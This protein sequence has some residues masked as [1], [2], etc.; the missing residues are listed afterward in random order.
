MKKKKISD[1][2]VGYACNNNCVHC[3]ISDNRDALLAQ[4]ASINRT[5]AECKQE[6]LNAK[7]MGTDE[8]VL[9]GG[10]ATIRKDF[11]DLLSIIYEQGLRVNLQ[12]NGRAF[13]DY[14]FAKKTAAFPNIYFTLALHGHNAEFHDRITQK[15]GSF[16]ETTTGI[17][18]LLESNKFVSIKLVLSKFNYKYLNELIELLDDLKIRHFNL[19]FPHGLGNASRYFFDVVPKYSEVKD[20]IISALEHSIKKNILF[21]TE[22]IPYCFLEGYEEFASEHFSVENQIEVRAIE[23]YTDNWHTKRLSIKKKGEKCIQCLFSEICEGPWV[24]YIENYGDSELKPI[25]ITAKNMMYILKKFQT[26]KDFRSGKKI[27][28]INRDVCQEINEKSM[29]LQTRNNKENG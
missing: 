1:I 15:N 9:T 13:Y 6:I 21:E 28:P 2:K 19:A 23:R 8:I 3:V 26:I 11:L 22:A 25:E 24:E 18:N 4:H 12:S 27:A 10:E 16:K 5:F 17:R 29:S 20:Y 14:E 7:L